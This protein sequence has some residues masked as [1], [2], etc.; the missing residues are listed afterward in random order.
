[1]RLPNPPRESG[2]ESEADPARSALDSRVV[3]N[4]YLYPVDLADEMHNVLG[5]RAA[6][7]ARGKNAQP[8]EY[9]GHPPL[10]R[11]DCVPRGGDSDITP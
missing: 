2:D 4:P 10:G 7:R 11:E 5:Y 1:M 3:K 6:G 8:G 9:P